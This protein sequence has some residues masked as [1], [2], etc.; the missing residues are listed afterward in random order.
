MYSDIHWRLFSPHEYIRTFIGNV[1]FHRIHWF[2][3][4][5]Q[6]KKLVIQKNL[7]KITFQQLML[8]IYPCPHLLGSVGSVLY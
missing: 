6:Q 7:G 5:Q 3:T 1:R 8:K 4:A 2:E